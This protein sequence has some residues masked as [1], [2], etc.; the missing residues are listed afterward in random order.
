VPNND[1]H[2]SYNLGDI[3]AVEVSINTGQRIIATTEDKLRLQLMLNRDDIQSREKWIAPFGVALTLLLTLITTDFHDFGLAA[4]VWH[5]IFIISLLLAIFWLIRTLVQ[6]PK[7]QSI[8][9]FIS[10]IKY[11]E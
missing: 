5:A 11:S 9:Q 4:A 6:R 8:E 1:N 7:R 10:K 3:D 2:D